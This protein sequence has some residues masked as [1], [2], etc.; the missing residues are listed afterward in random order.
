MSESPQI[1][2]LTTTAPGADSN[3]Y[4]LFNSV[5]AFGGGLLRV[6]AGGANRLQFGVENSEAGTLKGYMSPDKGTNWYQV[7]GDVAVAAAAATDISGPYDWLIDTY[8]DFKLDWVNGGAA[9]TTW[10][11]ILSLVAGDRA[12]GV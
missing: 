6:R 10:K 11:P 8:P 2:C 4:P 7:E 3:T 12:S 9:Q 1:G 5:T